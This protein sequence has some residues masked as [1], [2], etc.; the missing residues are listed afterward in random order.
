MTT[1]LDE[2]LSSFIDGEPN[3]PRLL[4]RALQQPHALQSL[5]AALELRIALQTDAAPSE[6]TIA[7]VETTIGR[8]GPVPVRRV[9]VL[10]WA[11]AA[12]VLL[13]IGALLGVA[14]RGTSTPPAPVGAPRPPAPDLVAEF[15]FDQRPD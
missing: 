13:A 3:D 1:E 10:Q 11:A 2:A 8:A 12:T 7:A 4:L 5:R 15:A 9:R 14:L 6:A